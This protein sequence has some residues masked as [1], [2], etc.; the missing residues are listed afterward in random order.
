[1]SEK[2]I[3]T[4]TVRDGVTHSG[5]RRT[6]YDLEQNGVAIDYVVHIQDARNWCADN[7]RFEENAPPVMTENELLADLDKFFSA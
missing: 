7:E 3:Y 1:M 4:Y 2:N 5:K 6:I